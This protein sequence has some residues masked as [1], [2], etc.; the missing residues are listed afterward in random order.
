VT[1]RIL[2]SF[3]CASTLLVSAPSR[4][5]SC[6]N[7]TE[8]GTC[9]DAKTLVFCDDG[10]LATMRCGAGE[11]CSHDERFHGAA[12]C[13]ATRYTGCGAVTELG[14]CA[15]DTLLYCSNNTV[16]ELVC[17]D[18]TACGAVSTDDGVEYDCVSLASTNEPTEDPKPVEPGEDGTDVD[19]PSPVEVQGTP[20]PSIEQGGAPAEEFDA[21]GGA[22]CN[23][24]GSG[25]WALVALLGLKRV[26]ARGGARCRG[27][28]R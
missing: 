7:V 1:Y 3:S 20:G 25:L 9:Q 27:P 24:A 21:S 26:S 5:E 23:G 6:G 18:G 28:R 11:L 22:G 2:L 4:A 19:E 10:E 8:R 15:G 16:E 12:G 17:P 13:I 14:L